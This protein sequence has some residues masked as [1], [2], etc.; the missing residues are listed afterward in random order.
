MLPISALVRPKRSAM[1]P[2]S[3]PPAAEAM[4]VTEPSSPAVGLSMPR[5]LMSDASTSE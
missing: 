4:S 2:N 1:T 3:R 5:S